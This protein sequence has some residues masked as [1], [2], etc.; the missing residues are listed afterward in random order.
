ME[1][2]KSQN[3]NPGLLGR[4]ICLVA[5]EGELKLRCPTCLGVARPLAMAHVFSPNT[6]ETAVVEL[7]ANHMSC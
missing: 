7:R 6:F 1:I 3:L 2:S 5:D 4:V